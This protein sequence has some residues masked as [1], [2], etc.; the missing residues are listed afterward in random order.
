MPT[1]RKTA[2]EADADALRAVYDH[3]TSYLDGLR[4]ARGQARTDELR[5]LINGLIDAGL[6][7]ESTVLD[8]TQRV[9]GKPVKDPY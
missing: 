3:L 1:S 7:A 4:D 8:A 2:N 6:A 9:T 5:S